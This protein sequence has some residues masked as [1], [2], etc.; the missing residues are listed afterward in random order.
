LIAALKDPRR[1]AF[2]VGVYSPEALSNPVVQ[3]PASKP[4][5]VSTDPQ[6]LTQFRRATQEGSLGLLAHNTLAGKL[7]YRLKTG[8][9]IFVIYGD[10]HF[11]RYVIYNYIDYRAVTPRLFEELK[12]GKRYSDYEVF[13]RAYTGAGNK[14]VLQTCLEK[15][16]R[17]TWG[18]RFIFAVRLDSP[19]QAERTALILSR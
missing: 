14:L 15:N 3:Q 17:S 1:K 8:D 13:Y 10:G 7:F 4:V 16:G 18:R 2:P 6:A 9:K 12:T 11:E 5:F 19:E